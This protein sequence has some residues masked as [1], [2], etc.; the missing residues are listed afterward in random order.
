MSLKAYQN[1]QAATDKWQGL[2]Y[3]TWESGAPVLKHVSFTA[4]ASNG[5][6]ITS[7]TAT[8]TSSARPTWSTSSRAGP[9]VSY[10]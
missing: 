5:S 3:E 9:S 7:Y 4:P 10:A 1:A 8:C 2:D 6:P